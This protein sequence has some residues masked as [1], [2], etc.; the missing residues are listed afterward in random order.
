LREDDD[1][2]SLLPT[3]QDIEDRVE[4]ML[5]DQSYVHKKLDLLCEIFPTDRHDWGDDEEKTEQAMGLFGLTVWFWS[6]SVVGT[7]FCNRTRHATR[8]TSHSHVLRVTYVAVSAASAGFFDGAVI[9]WLRVGSIRKPRCGKRGGEV[10]V[11]TK[12]QELKQ[13]G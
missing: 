1:A 10:T 8:F 12:H 11:Y 7:W 6:L 2:E 9:Y 5:A 3:L 13:A 4:Q